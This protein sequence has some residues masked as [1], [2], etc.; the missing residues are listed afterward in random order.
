MA[1]LLLVVYKKTGFTGVHIIFLNFLLTTLGVLITTDQ[2]SIFEPKKEI[3]H[4]L[5]SE[6]CNFYSSKKLNIYHRRVNIMPSHYVCSCHFTTD[7]SRVMRKP[8]FCICENVWLIS[9]FF[10]YINNTISLPPKSEISSL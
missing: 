3:C 8:A 10:H 7:M 9:G 6:I 4:K 5:P 1:K 2:T